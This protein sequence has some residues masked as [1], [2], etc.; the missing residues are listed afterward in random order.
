MLW[1]LNWFE[2]VIGNWGVAIL[3]LTLVVR[4][5]LYP[6][7]K[8]SSDSMKAMAALKPEMDK[9]K[10]KFGGDKMR[11][12]EE[13]MKLYR[14]N[15]VNPLS[16][17]LPMVLQMPIWI[18]LYRTIYSSVDLYQQPFIGGWIDDLS[19]KDPFYIL[20]V[21]LGGLMFAQQKLTPST[22]D[23][24]QAKMMLY[25]MPGFMTLI[26]LNLPSGLNLYIM[27]SSLLSVLSQAYINR[28]GKAL[29][30]TR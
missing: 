21:A 8:K 29:T 24:A 26:M 22:M 1:L 28:K 18:A 15:G 11:F 25:F 27:A 5:L 2:G 7:T 13:L 20:P 16:G 23:S 3:L 9:L 19:A 10:E 30:K 4:S 6:I 12:N 14:A 17:C